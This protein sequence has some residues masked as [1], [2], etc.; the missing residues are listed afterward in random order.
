MIMLCNLSLLQECHVDGRGVYVSG[1]DSSLLGKTI[2]VDA[3]D[4]G[5]LDIVFFYPVPSMGFILCLI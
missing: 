4:A 3:D 2:G 1:V 5:K